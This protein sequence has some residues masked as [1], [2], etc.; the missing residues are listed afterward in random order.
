[1]QPKY[2]AYLDYLERHRRFVLEEAAQLCVSD[3]G[4]RHDLSKYEPDEFDA[5]AEYFYGIWRVEN[6]PA[7]ADVQERF[8]YAW[9]LHQKRNDHHW[10]YW[11]LREDDGAMKVLPM[12][13]LAM[14]EMLADWRGASRAITGTDNTPTWYAKNA[15]NMLLH[16]A[17]KAWIEVHL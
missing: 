15:A 9:M 13:E 2:D 1:M 6:V 10:Q 7:P 4:V 12:P 17:T 14:R 11:L 3:R 16:P 8:D 5:Y